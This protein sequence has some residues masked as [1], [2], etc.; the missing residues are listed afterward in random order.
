M[1]K[2]K[3]VL[4]L[5]LLALLPLLALAQDSSFNT[6]IG[7]DLNPEVSG[8]VE[9]WHFWGSPVRRT[10][11]RRVVAI[12]EQQLPNIKV[13]EVFKPWGDIW[14]ANIAAVA[15]GSGMPDVI[16]A[17]RG[18]MPRD[19]EA[20]I[21]EDLQPYIERDGVNPD[22][23]WPFTWQQ[24]LYDGDSY[25]IPFETDVRVLYY[26]KNLFEQAGLDPNDPP[27]TWE[28]LE[29]AAEA[30]TVMDDSGK[31]TRIGF[32][33]LGGNGPPGIYYMLDDADLVRDGEVTINT[34]EALETV[35]WMKD[36]IDRYGG[37]DAYNGFRGQFSAPP[38]DIFMAGG[39][40]MKLDTAGY[41]SILNFYRPRVQLENGDTAEMQW[42]VA[43][44]PH[45]A[46][47]D[48]ANSSGG[49]ALSIPRGAENP[50]AAW[51]FIKCAASV[52]AQISWARDTYAIPT[53]IEAANDP[54]LMADPNWGNFVNSLESS[55]VYDFIPAYPAWEQELNNRYEQVW[56]GQ[57]TPEQMLEEA[58]NAVDAEIGAQ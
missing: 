25:G 9:F 43:P 5:M 32:D 17:D 33:V 48:P 2:V 28:E 31:L 45:A 54:T 6:G 57:I 36:W 40:A 30:L 41:S 55:V 21:Y 19:A 13:T 35:Q 27:E 44:P 3:T 42:G 12:C 1:S 50:E 22:A 34:P 14:T 39:A 7:A 58:Q 23:F 37:F 46:D 15:A 4:A 38:N 18:Q 56:T 52:P 8:D 24:T 53:V 16:V 26:N 10:A 51:E 29:Q 20:Q 11:V 47:A 49:F